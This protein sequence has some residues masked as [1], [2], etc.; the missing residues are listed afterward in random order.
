MSQDKVNIEICH[1][2]NGKT[3]ISLHI[4]AGWAPLNNPVSQRYWKNVIQSPLLIQTCNID[5]VETDYWRDSQEYCTC[6]SYSKKHVVDIVR[7]T[8][9]WGNSNKY[10]QNMFLGV[11]KKIIPFLLIK[12]FHVLVSALNCFLMAILGNKFSCYN[13][14]PVYQQ[15]CNTVMFWQYWYVLSVLPVS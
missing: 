6:I 8:P 3:Q 4:W 7:I 14:G 9:L 2:H 13:K 11:I 1:T 5:K 12:L 10:Q 15:W